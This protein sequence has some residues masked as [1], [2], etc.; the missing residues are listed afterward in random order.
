MT[1]SAAAAHHLN[2]DDADIDLP[3]LPAHEAAAGRRT[4]RPG[5]C[6]TRR[7]R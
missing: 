2:A 3:S 7:R 6:R 1:P 5:W 4:R